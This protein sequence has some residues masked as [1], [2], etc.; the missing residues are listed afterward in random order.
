MILNL[1]VTYKLS[2]SCPSIRASTEIDL[3]YKKNTHS[4][5]AITQPFFYLFWSQLVQTLSII[6]FSNCLPRGHI[7]F[8][9]LTDGCAV[10]GVEFLKTF[11]SQH[12]II[13][14][15]TAKTSISQRIYQSVTTDFM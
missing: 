6:K 13:D 2:D 8:S 12:I 3:G 10:T 1:L 15:L 14:Y 4:L 11:L 5:S 9:Q 7:R